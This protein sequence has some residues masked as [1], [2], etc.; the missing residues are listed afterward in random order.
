MGRRSAGSRTAAGGPARGGRPRKRFGQHFLAP[1]WA[2]K[3]VEV[4]APEPGDVFL[5]IGPGT[6]AL[7][8]PLAAHHVPILAI[9][10]DREL[11][12]DLL[13]RVP[14]H[15]TVMTGDVLKT[16]VLP[17]LS[18]LE[19]HRPI[20]GPG[21]GPPRPRRTRV[22]GN[23]PYYIAAPILVRLID[24]HRRHGFFT[25]ATVML[26]REVADRLTARPG[27]K[28]YGVLTIML[29][30]HA[31]ITRL[32]DLPPGA[33][34]PPPKVRSSVVRL[35]FGPPTVR[36]R[37]EALFE[38]MV[39]ALFGQRRKTLSNAL[40]A[41]DPTGPAVLALAGIDSRR[42]PETLSVEELARLAEL[43]ASVRQDAGPRS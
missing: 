1:A 23:L 13:Q 6:G 15:V 24:I 11:V 3:V 41:F 40:K 21:A 8:L 43:F 20:A 22:V 29:A 36:I 19:P 25:D 10:I 9:E 18:G 17:F 34:T 33:F 7:T 4:I 16:D 32:L 2:R 5:E 30:V 26:Q 28:D 12:S 38:R 37:D 27:A 39:K 35:A 14:P 42:R 31:R